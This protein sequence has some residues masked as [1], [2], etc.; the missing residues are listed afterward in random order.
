MLPGAQ[1]ALAATNNAAASLRP[2]IDARPCDESDP[3]PQIRLVLAPG[4]VICYGGTVGVM[5]VDDI[6]A[7]GLASGGYWGYVTCDDLTQYLF[8]PN[9]FVRLDCNVIWIGIT[10]P[11]WGTKASH[12][13]MKPVGQP[14]GHSFGSGTIP[15]DTPWNG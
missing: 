9:D 4:A 15:Q 5:R 3:T 11:N 13:S 8:D 2:A 14:E 12:R 10:P 1:T 7:R 6:Y